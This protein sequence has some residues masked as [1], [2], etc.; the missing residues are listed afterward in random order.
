MIFK[1]L[2]PVTGLIA[3]E[4]ITKV[5]SIRAR[6]V[7]NLGISG[8]PDNRDS[9]IYRSVLRNKDDFFR[10][11]LIL[12]NGEDPGR[13]SYDGNKGNG[14]GGWEYR[15]MNGTGLL[16]ELTRAYSTEPER[17]DEVDKIVKSLVQS[18]NANEVVTDETKII[19]Q[20][21]FDQDNNMKVSH[22]K[23]QH[24]IVKII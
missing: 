3:F 14:T 18:E 15:L 17:L 13:P 7:L 19:D 11:L 10:Y 21:N 24:V 8:L 2:S 5:S 6:L 22:G 16:E 9:E 23:K 20:S 12:L 1:N 4:L